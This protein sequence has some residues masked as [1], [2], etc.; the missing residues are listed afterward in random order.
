MEGDV[1]PLRSPAD[2]AMGG[3][4]RCDKGR[5]GAARGVEKE[6]SGAVGDSVFLRLGTLF[7]SDKTQTPNGEPCNI[8]RGLMFVRTCWCASN[9]AIVKTL[10][11]WAM[12]MVPEQESWEEIAL[13]CLASL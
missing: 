12:V 10:N 9:C 8:A 5:F 1:T 4:D 3:P 2:S 7:R 11:L 13:N 6:G